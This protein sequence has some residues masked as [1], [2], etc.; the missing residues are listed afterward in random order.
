[1]AS[2][3]ELLIGALEANGWVKV[4]FKQWDHGSPNPSILVVRRGHDVRRF[5]LYAW[6]ITGEGKGRK[7]TDFRVQTTRA[8]K[9]GPLKMEPGYTSLGVGWDEDRNVFAAFDVWTKRNTSWSSS[10]HIRRSLLEAAASKGWEE[11]DREDGPEIAF[12]PANVGRFLDWV[13]RVNRPRVALLEALEVSL[14]SKDVAVIDVDPRRN[15]KAPW[16]R[17]RD[18]IAVGRGGRL[19]DKTLWRID[20]VSEIDQTAAGRNRRWYLRFTCQRWGIIEDPEFLTK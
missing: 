20:D 1:M 16:L 14:T 18:H 15:A 12:T 9:T 17:P 8:D 11:E 2:P 19:V 10:V 6:R 5:L 3:H 13:V 7:K 4:G